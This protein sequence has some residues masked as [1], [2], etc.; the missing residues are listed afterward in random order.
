MPSWTLKGSWNCSTVRDGHGPLKAETRVRI[1]LG[2]PLDGARFSGV[3]REMARRRERPRKAVVKLDET[4][5]IGNL[6]VAAMSRPPS[7]GR[8]DATPSAR[9][10]TPLPCLTTTLIP[11]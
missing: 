6:R 5:G 9:F 11:D 7:G 4:V 10:L 3:S 1:P 2:P 8:P